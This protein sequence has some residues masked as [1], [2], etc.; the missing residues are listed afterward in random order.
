[1]T[2]L[3]IVI[4]NQHFVNSLFSEKVVFQIVVILTVS[5]CWCCIHPFQLFLP[6]LSRLFFL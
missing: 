6:L 1:L 3:G 4:G 2:H 5:R